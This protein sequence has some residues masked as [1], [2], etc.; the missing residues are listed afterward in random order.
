MG[1]AIIL[2]DGKAGHENQSKAFARALGLDFQLVPVKFKSPFHKILSY[3]FDRLGIRTVGLLQGLDKFLHSSTHQLTNSSTSLS[4][5]L[6]NNLQL[7]PHALRFKGC[8]RVLEERPIA[9]H[10]D[11]TAKQRSTHLNN[12]YPMIPTHSWKATELR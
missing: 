1:K 6:Y 5:I 12:L 9:L 11:Y 8:E 7:L 4:P 10:W 2:T 3:L